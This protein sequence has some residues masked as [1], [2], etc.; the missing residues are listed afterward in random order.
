MEREE[1]ISNIFSEM[2]VVDSEI[3]INEIK[4][5]STKY[6]FTTLSI[7]TK[8]TYIS[9]E[10]RMHV[11]LKVIKDFLF[12]KIDEINSM[13][14]YTNTTT[15]GSEYIT[16]NS[17]DGSNVIMIQTNKI[18][19]KNLIRKIFNEMIKSS[20]ESFY[21]NCIDGFPYYNNDDELYNDLDIML[22]EFTKHNFIPDVNKCNQNI[23]DYVN[24]KPP[25]S[26]PSSKRHTED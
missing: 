2:T 7:N 17:S 1:D 26:K 18:T 23:I 22:L 24:S 4:Y 25:P 3:N 21:E 15:I 12:D 9:I 11:S 20:I 13:N 19:I 14:G 6:L 16:I 10:I 5:Y 8:E